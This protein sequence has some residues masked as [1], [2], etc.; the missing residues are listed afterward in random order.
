MA[1]P[2]RDIA[3]EF[4]FHSE[5]MHS[6]NLSPPN[7]IISIYDVFENLVESVTCL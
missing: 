1:I 5:D 3:V 6:L 2:S 7:H 4:S